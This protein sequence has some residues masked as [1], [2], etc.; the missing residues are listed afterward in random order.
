MSDV[1]TY[2][3]APRDY[4]GRKPVLFLAGGIGG[5]PDWQ[6][7]AFRALDDL[8][9]VVANPR[10]AN[11]PIH[12]PSAAAAQIAWEHRY[13][14]RADVVLFWFPDSGPVPQPIALFELGCYAAAQ[15]GKPVAVGADPAYVRRGD[16][17]T[18]LRLRRP[19]LAVHSTLADTCAQARLL[20]DR[21]HSAAR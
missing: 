8:V 10:Q 6:S 7:D 18:Q 3:Q 21:L 12:Q 2:L 5:C 17:V 16:V 20:V 9:I 1:A 14:E 4:N 15:A 19:D 11:F 13:L